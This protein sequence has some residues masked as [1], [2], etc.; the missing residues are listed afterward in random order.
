MYQ[1]IVLCHSL[2]Y[3]VTDRVGLGIRT[4]GRVN[5][6][7]RVITARSIQSISGAFNIIKVRV[8]KS[9]IKVQSD[10][11]RRRMRELFGVNVC[12]AIS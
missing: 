1:R 7:S 2:L 3:R 4:S 5:F 11:F 6:Q 8:M 9:G 12:D 10:W